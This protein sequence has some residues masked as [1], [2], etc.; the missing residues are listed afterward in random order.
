MENKLIYSILYINKSRLMYIR[1]VSSL[2]E[3]E[4]AK[5]HFYI[6][7]RTRRHTMGFISNLWCRLSGNMPAAA[8]PL[9]PCFLLCLLRSCP[10]SHLIL[11]PSPDQQSSQ[12]LREN[13]TEGQ[14]LPPPEDTVT[15]SGSWAT[16]L[17]ASEDM[18]SFLS[19]IIH[20]FKLFSNLARIYNQNLLLL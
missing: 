12:Q 5:K 8:F 3:G 15:L 18:A 4:G 10:S 20:P 11:N 19:L 6:T 16:T 9:T 14:V 7:Q 1:V 2:C 17:C 13:S